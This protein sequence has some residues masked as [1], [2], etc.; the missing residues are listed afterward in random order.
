[1]IFDDMPGNSKLIISLK[2]HSE[3]SLEIGRS[4]I[5]FDQQRKAKPQTDTMKPIPLAFIQSR[6]RS[7]VLSAAVLAASATLAQNVVIPFNNNSN[8]ATNGLAAVWHWWGGAATTHEWTTNDA[9]N[10][11]SSGSI[12]IT[13]T[14]PTGATADYQYSVGLSLGGE[15]NYGLQTTLNPLNYTNFEFDLMWDTNSTINITNHMTGGDPN[16][17]GFGFVATQYGQTWVPNAQQPVLLADGQWHHY[18][19]PINPA[20]PVIP[21]VIFK[22]Y[23]GYNAANEGT[24][25]AFWVDNLQFDFNTN[26]T[27]PKPVMLAAKATKGLNLIAAQSGSQYQRQGVRSTPADAHQWY[28]NTNP[29]TYQVTIAEFPSGATYAGFQSHIMLSP[30]GGTTEPDWN[31]PNCVYVQ[32]QQTAGGAGICNYRFKTNSPNSNGVGGSGFF[33]TGYL[34][35]LIAPSILGTWS[36]TFTNNSVAT[37]VGPGGVSTN[38]DMGADAAAFFNSATPSMATYFGVQPNNPANIGQRAVFSRIKITDGAEVVVDDTFPLSDPVN[39]ADPLLWIQ[40]LDGNTASAIKVVDQP[41]LWVD[42]NKPDSYFLALLAASNL[43]S[44][45]TDPFLTI[46]DHGTR[47]GVFVGTNTTVNFPEAMYFRLY[48]TNTP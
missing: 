48:G 14:W 47:R 34:G 19:I 42:W 39:E 18:T 27:I 11:P 28:G 1:V 5:Q 40:E 36:V 35:Q 8:F 29:V 12:K 46:R 13:A 43:T 17:F 37:I 7:I 23:M 26:V 16:G 44:G 31:N 38:F 6:L 33:G 22:K 24:T 3:K 45:W 15:A 32:F 2:P 25:S 30:D 10:N 41:A 21:G 9:G 4:S 20:W